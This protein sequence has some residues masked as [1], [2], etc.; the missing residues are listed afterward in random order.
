MPEYVAAVNDAMPTSRT[1]VVFK[2]GWKDGALA[3][4]DGMLA[5]A[6]GADPTAA[7]A[8]AQRGPRQGRQQVVMASAS[9]GGTPLT[10]VRP[11]APPRTARAGRLD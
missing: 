10:D 11:N 7:C 2:E 5:I 8:K 9:A 3:I 6:N 4:V 1:T